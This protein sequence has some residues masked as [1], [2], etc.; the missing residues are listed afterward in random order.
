MRA[1]AV[2]SGDTSRTRSWQSRAWQ[3]QRQRQEFTARRAS[4]TA[5]GSRASAH[6]RASA[7]RLLPRLC[8]VTPSTTTTSSRRCNARTLRYGIWWCMW[9]IPSLFSC[10]TVSYSR[11]QIPR[12]PTRALQG[13]NETCPIDSRTRWSHMPKAFRGSSAVASPPLTSTSAASNLCRPPDS[14]LPDAS[15]SCAFLMAASSAASTSLKLCEPS[16]WPGPACAGL[17]T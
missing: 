17:R 16:A 14:F 10:N 8:D 7:S 2:T 15:S 3:R 13:P 9:S 5:I 12:N 1:T 11:Q 6:R 4:T